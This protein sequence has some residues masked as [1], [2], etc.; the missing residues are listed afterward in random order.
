MFV[1]HPD[2]KS[3][4]GAPY[5]NHKITFLSREIRISGNVLQSLN[6]IFGRGEVIPSQAS[7]GRTI[8]MP[9]S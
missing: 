4:Q 7:A 5:V 1:P 6:I 9:K 8:R 2:C 3:V